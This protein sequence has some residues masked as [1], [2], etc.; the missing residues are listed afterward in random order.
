MLGWRLHPRSFKA[1]FIVSA[2]S[3]R[4]E[5]GGYQRVELPSQAA[6]RVRAADRDLTSTTS[7]GLHVSRALPTEHNH[8]RVLPPAQGAALATAHTRWHAEMSWWGSLRLGA[9][10]ARSRM[11]T[12]KRPAL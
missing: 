2:F 9:P 10:G 1:E 7:W 8:C 4:S 5:P 3:V 11:S 12:E 6:G